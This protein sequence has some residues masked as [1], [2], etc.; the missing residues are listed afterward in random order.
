MIKTIIFSTT[1]FTSGMCFSQSIYVGPELGI[2]IIQVEKQDIGRDFQLGFYGGG[3]FEYQLNKSFSLKSGLYLSQTKQSYISNDTTAFDFFGLADSTMTIQGIDL[4]TYNTTT[5]RQ[6][7]NY[8]QLP[9]L[10]NYKWKN[11]NIFAGGYIGFMISSNRKEGTVSTTPFMSII[12]VDSLDPTGFFSSF[13]PKPYEESFQETSDKTNLRIFDYGIKAGLG[14]EFD[15]LGVNCSFNY[16]IPDF[17][18]E[19]GELKLQNHLSFQLSAFYLIELGKS[20]SKSSL[21]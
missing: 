17:R 10:A 11:I 3:F 9:I 1:L 18:N 13:F 12:D 16:G 7:Q 15:K 4:N 20:K 5:N 21:Q 19:R 8:I 14:Y 2:N 6:T